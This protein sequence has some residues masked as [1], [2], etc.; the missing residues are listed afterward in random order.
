[1][2][3]VGSYFPNIM[4]KSSVCAHNATTS[5]ENK[6]LL[7]YVFTLLGHSALK[8]YAVA[9]S[10]RTIPSAI[11]LLWLELLAPGSFSIL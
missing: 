6:A 4:S 3:G 10:S 9:V 5:W 2:Q 11:L 7:F 1:M 8:H